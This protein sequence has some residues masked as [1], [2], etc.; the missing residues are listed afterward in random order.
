MSGVGIH[1]MLPYMSMQA[2]FFG[3][4]STVRR[5]E[6]RQLRHADEEPT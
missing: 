5:V 1:H 6:R 3:H 2:T 4:W